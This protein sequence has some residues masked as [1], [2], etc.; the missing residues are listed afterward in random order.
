MASL[1][2]CTKTFTVSS[3]QSI[4]TLSHKFSFYSLYM[5]FRQYSH[6]CLRSLQWGV[7]QAAVCVNIDDLSLS[8]ASLGIWSFRTIFTI[9][10]GSKTTQRDAGWVKNGCSA[11]LD[12]LWGVGVR[13]SADALTAAFNLESL[14]ANHLYKQTHWKR[15]HQTVPLPNYTLNVRRLNKLCSA[16]KQSRLF[17]GENIQ[18]TFFFLFW[19]SEETHQRSAA[20]ELRCFDSWLIY[21][22]RCP[23]HYTSPCVQGYHVEQQPFH[24]PTNL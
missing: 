6:I 7:T 20:S 4:R 16:E 10:I 17:W 5:Y 23:D 13:G 21:N 9:C 15:S 3:Q 12:K 2:C 1:I 22:A 19:R 8:V 24:I 14:E 11:K 18:S